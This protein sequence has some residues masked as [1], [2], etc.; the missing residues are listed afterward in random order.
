MHYLQ[1]LPKRRVMFVP[2]L[3]APVPHRNKRRSTWEQKVSAECKNKIQNDSAPEPGPRKCDGV[4]RGNP[5]SRNFVSKSDTTGLHNIQTH[6]TKVN[7]WNQLPLTDPVPQ[8]NEQLEMYINK[9]KVFAKS[10][11]K[12]RNTIQR[13]ESPHP[14]NALCTRWKRKKRIASRR[15]LKWINH[16]FIVFA[17]Y[18]IR[19]LIFQMN[20]NSPTTNRFQLYQCI[21]K[22]LMLY[23]WV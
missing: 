1:T 6:P 4:V 19:H 2:Q 20:V 18:S 9:T 10:E 8:C 16:V 3:S 22:K 12:L 13:W 5:K 23:L 14:T 21:T 15:E 7:F 11:K 17:V